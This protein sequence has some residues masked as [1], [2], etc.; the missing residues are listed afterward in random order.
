MGLLLRR[1]AIVGLITL[2]AAEMTA[3]H[4]FGWGDPPLFDLD[5]GIEYLHRP[6]KTY[7]QLGHTIA[8][9]AHSMRSPDFP[10]AKA[11]PRELRVMV[12]GDSIVTGGARIDQG[13]LATTLLAPM[14]EESLGRKVVVGN[15][16]AGSWGPPNQLAYAE[17][18]GLFEADVVILVLNS[19]D[20]NDVPGLEPLGAAWPTSKPLLAIQEP[21]RKLFER[22]A[23]EAAV[24]IGTMTSA[25]PPGKDAQAMVDDALTQLVAKARAAGT[26]GTP[27]AVGAL[28][29]RARSEI[30]GEG[31]GGGVAG[32]DHLREKLRELGVPCWSSVADDTQPGFIND[33]ALFIRDD[34]VHPSAAGQARLAQLLRHITLQLRDTAKPDSPGP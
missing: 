25:R 23:P 15:I 29:F 1:L 8:I 18:F 26:P 28:L 3:R 9:N 30:G 13:E 32:L 22:F 17:R 14:L 34:P 2:L 6:A 24:A 33:S 20:V 16:A 12:I 5:P 7:H 31:G 27:T 21:A 10:R 19:G 11:D 4:Y